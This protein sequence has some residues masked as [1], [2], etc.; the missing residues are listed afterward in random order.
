[1]AD[2]KS[3]K[4]EEVD[5]KKMKSY[6]C[7]CAEK[8]FVGSALRKSGEE[9]SQEWATDWRRRLTIIEFDQKVSGGKNRQRGREGPQAGNGQK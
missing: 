3:R 8:Q 5:K 4:N 7:Q 1:M 6:I 9:I 2:K